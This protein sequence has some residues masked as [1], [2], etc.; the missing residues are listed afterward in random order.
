LNFERAKLSNLFV[1]GE[2]VK[3]EKIK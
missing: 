3:G 1:K 2:F